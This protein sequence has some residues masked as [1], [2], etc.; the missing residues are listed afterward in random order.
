MA[1]ARTVFPKSALAVGLRVLKRVAVQP[2]G[3]M[4][5]AR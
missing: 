3:A 5:A 2:D 1:R 4:E